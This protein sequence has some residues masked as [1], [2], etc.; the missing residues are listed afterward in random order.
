MGGGMEGSREKVL[1]TISGRGDSSEP[2][3]LFRQKRVRWRVVSIP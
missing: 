1:G 3:S 2:V